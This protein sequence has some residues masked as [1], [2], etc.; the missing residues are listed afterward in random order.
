MP[1]GQH[2]DSSLPT[3]PLRL[4]ELIAAASSPDPVINDDGSTT[5]YVRL[6]PSER[7]TMLPRPVRKS[8]RSGDELT[9]RANVRKIPR[10]TARNW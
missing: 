6:I 7:F 8:R 5:I 2:Q 1:A 10:R 4:S 3:A 9:A